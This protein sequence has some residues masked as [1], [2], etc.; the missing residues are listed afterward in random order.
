MVKSLVRF[1]GIRDSWEL[2]FRKF[3][4]NECEDLPHLPVPR[5]SQLLGHARILIQYMRNLL[6]SSD[7]CLRILE[8]I[9]MDSKDDQELWVQFVLDCSVL[10][11]VIAA[12]QKDSA[13]LGYLFS[14]TRTYVYSLH[15][16]RLKLLGRWC[17]WLLYIVH[18]RFGHYY[19]WFWS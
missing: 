15:K 12:A 18:D 14:A 6:K 4:H 16:T 7:Q 5:C 19:R 8:K 2:V 10:R 1:I 11:I 17:P 9:I 3:C 13:L